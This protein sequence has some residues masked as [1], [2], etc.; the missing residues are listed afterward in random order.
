MVAQNGFLYV[1]FSV[2]KGIET[3]L[4]YSLLIAMRGKLEEMIITSPPMFG[5]FV[6]AIIVSI[7]IVKS[8]GTIDQSK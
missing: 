2:F 6:N 7:I 1:G 8:N 4:N 3:M 5:H